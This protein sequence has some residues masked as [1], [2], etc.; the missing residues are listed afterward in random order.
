VT[1]D[2]RDVAAAFGLGWAPEPPALPSRALLAALPMQYARRHLVLPIGPQNGS[3][4]A[5]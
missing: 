5:R 3:D 4:T 1:G 2:G